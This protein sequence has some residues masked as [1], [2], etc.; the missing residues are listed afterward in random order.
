MRLGRGPDLGLGIGGAPGFPDL[1]PVAG[2]AAA[3]SNGT[4]AAP[5]ARDASAAAVG[6]P[7]GLRTPSPG[8]AGRMGSRMGLTP[9]SGTR[10]TARISAR[11][12]QPVEGVELSPFLFLRDS[13]GLL[14]NAQDE[15]VTFRW[16]RSATHRAC[17]F[18]GCRHLGSA[19]AEQAAK[20]PAAVQCATMAKAG[21]SPERSLYCS[22]ECYQQAWSGH[23][24][25]LELAKAP[26]GT[27]DF[28]RAKYTPLSLPGDEEAKR[29]AP[30]DSA[31]SG[32]STSASSGA[33][34]VGSGSASS[35]AKSEDEDE[36]EM[37]ASEAA[38][39]AAEALYSGPAPPLQP[40]LMHPPPSSAAGGRETG[41][42]AKEAAAAAAAARSTETKAEWIDLGEARTYV[43]KAEDVWHRIRLLVEADIGGTDGVLNETA[44]THPVLPRPPLAAQ[45]TFVPLTRDPRTG[46]A[47]RADVPPAQVVAKEGDRRHP[48]TVRV[49]SYNT[50]AEIYANQGV[51]PYCP[52]W[53]LSWQFRRDLIIR[54]LLRLD[55]DLV[56]LQE[57][58][59]DHFLSMLNPAMKAAGYDSQYKQKTRESMGLEGKVD[60]CAFFYKAGRFKLL[61]KYVVEFNAA[62]KTAS[63]AEANE[64]RRQQ[65]T[66][67]QRAQHMKRLDKQ[68]HRLLR[69]N[70][71]QVVVLQMTKDAQG[72]AITESQGEQPKICVAN[73]HL[74]WDPE[75]ADVK[76]WQTQMLVRELEKLT[77]KRGLPLIL[78]GDFNSEPTSAVHKLLAGNAKAGHR[79]QLQ[80]EDLPADPQG[81]LPRQMARLSHGLLLQSAYGSV[82]GDEPRFTNYTEQYVGCLDYIWISADRA[83]P[84][85][86]LSVP[87]ESQ[88]TATSR[89]PLPNPQHPSDHVSLCA[90]IVIGMPSHGLARSALPA[91]AMGPGAAGGIGG[92]SRG[93]VAGGPAPGRVMPGGLGT[94]RGNGM[95]QHSSH[96]GQQGGVGVGV[97][98]GVGGGRPAPG[99]AGHGQ[100]GGAAASAGSRAAASGFGPPVG[101]MGVM[102][103]SRGMPVGGTA[104]GPGMMLGGM[105]GG[106]RGV[107][108]GGPGMGRFGGPG[109]AGNGAGGV[110][111]QGQMLGSSPFSG[112]GGSGGGY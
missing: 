55:A 96:Q 61:E 45:R 97:G 36:S 46:T 53:A 9:G 69:D 41:G 7:P 34:V 3:Q 89:S 65:A 109:M 14:I 102:S 67:A 52:N 103:A 110:P 92:L 101:R 112:G 85:A 48:H 83:T 75:F 29:E 111:R 11:L 49:V 58:Q 22:P 50:L 68:L 57:V 6:G 106:G 87:H 95:Q 21:A 90:D 23:R 51:Y 93:V 24:Q 40:G 74:F 64:L 43:P 104:G 81:I 47:P 79:C 72:N 56:C 107:G 16:Q 71:A 82:L 30:G 17:A 44:V 18:S 19:P 20:W 59:A 31:A 100:L 32:A 88:L 105:P 5:P 8:K 10:S 78:C 13:T 63:E 35:S 62:A 66:P 73:T 1:G 99:V 26:D 2:G 4:G 77:A 25:Y 91:G 37:T 38:F 70:V 84:V 39:A 33:G 28:S 86:V 94:F 108:A 98:M 76:L 12:S 80:H 15:R 60:G 42:K 54:E 27:M